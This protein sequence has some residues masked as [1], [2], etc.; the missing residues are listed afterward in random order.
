MLARP[1]PARQ[2][3]S[4]PRISAVRRPQSVA[5][6]PPLYSL[7]SLHA[8]SRRLLTTRVELLPRRKKSS[9]DTHGSIFQRSLATAINDPIRGESPYDH[10]PEKYMYPLSPPPHLYD[11]RPFDPS[12]PLLL[13]PAEDPF[14]RSRISIHGIPGGVDEMMSVFDACLQVGKLDRAALVIT[15]LSESGAIQGASLTELHNQYLRAAID[16][17][18]EQPDSEWAQSLHKW[19]EL[20]IRGKGLP[21]TP[22]TVACM[23]KISLLSTQGPRLE[24]L[25]ARYMDLMPGD[26][27]YQVLSEDD[28]LTQ[29][30]VGIIASIYQPASDLLEDW[31]P[32]LQDEE[33]QLLDTEVSS[34]EPVNISEMKAER[35]DTPE[36][37]AVDQKG[38]GLKT[39]RGVLSFFS[40]VEGRDL[41]KLSYAERREIQA[42][43]E[44]DC[45]DAAISRWREENQALMKMG[46][47]TSLSTSGLNS[48]LYEWQCALESRLEEEFELF[49]VA[50]TREKKNDADQDR[51]ICSP[52]LK[53]STPA[54]LS[55]VT[56]ISV[57]NAMSSVGIDGGI[58]LSTLLSHISKAVE[59][60]I[61]QMIRQKRIEEAKRKAKTRNNMLKLKQKSAT[62][63]STAQPPTETPST[64]HVKTES[65]VAEAESNVVEES[66][67]EVRSWPTLIR[68]KVGVA[69]LSALIDTAKMNV[70]REHPETKALVSQRQPA[71]AH[72]TI[73]RKGKKVGLVM[74]NKFLVELLKR[75]PPADFL[76]RHLPMLVEPE[77]WT[78][79]DKGGFV[80]YPAQLVRIKN[81]EKDQRVYA[82]AAVQRGD[83]EQVSKGLDVLGRTGWRINRPVFDVMLEA[84]NSG[85]PIANI[86]PLDPQIPIPPEPEA[87]D[88]P[89]QRREWLNAVKAAENEKSGLHSER[90][91]M[92]FQFEIARAFKDQ[93]FYFPHNM[94][95]R[96]RAYPI[97]TYLNHMGA[98]HVRGLL[99]FA[100]GKELGE[101]GLRWLKIHLANVFGYDKASL[102][103]RE[104]FVTDHL[105]DIYDSVANPLTGKRWWLKAEDAW[106]CLAT[107]F[108]LKAAL[109]SPDPTKFVSHLPVHQDGTCNGL[110][111]YAALGG[112]IWGAQQVNLLPG[113]RPADVYSA[114][115]DLV[116]EGIAKDLE[117][118]DNVIAKAVEGKI[119]RKVVKQTVMTN[120]YGVTF[121][122]AKA[123]VQKQ[124]DAAYPNIRQETGIPVA[125][126]ASYVAT[127]VFG[128]LSTMFRGAHNIQY[129]L[130]ECAGRVCRALTPEQMDRIAKGEVPPPRT[131]GMRKTTTKSTTDEILG[132]FRST[133]VW[134]T[135]LR[136]PI[137]QPYRKNGTR[138]IS[139]SM[140]DLTLQVPESSDPVNR[141]KQLQAFPPN[142]IHSLDASHMLLS[143]LQC[144][145]RGLSFAAV[146][147][148]F[149]THAADVD[150]MN[151][152][153]RDSF[154]R[155]HS[156][157]VIGRLASEFKARYK[158]SIYLSKV[159]RYSKVGNKIAALRKK[160]KLSLK[161]ELLEERERMRLLASSDPEEVKKG[162]EMQTP[163]SIFEEMS[164]PQ[165][166]NSAEDMEGM[167]LGDIPDV[168]EILASAME[169]VDE[170]GEDDLALASEP[171]KP[172]KAVKAVKA[173]VD[174]ATESDTNPSMKEVM[175]NLLDGVNVSRFEQELS[176]SI[177]K[178]AKAKAK[179]KPTFIN[180][181]LPLDFPEVPEKGDFDVT[182]LRDSQ[183]FFS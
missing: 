104:A 91:F 26:A 30:D 131:T 138:V 152:V 149:W 146:H 163:A 38:L 182:R 52:F 118:S 126:L 92:N 9:Q 89:L 49:E 125:V 113:E 41:S 168:N 83:M 76:A 180:V 112:D 7:Y 133:V 84:W 107:S 56:I 94:D 8:S 79:F 130:G 36:V 175:D 154:I 164:A 129:W 178:T 81:G 62:S 73:N 143:A 123:Q 45:V 155:I 68:T 24:R 88:D 142:F 3:L 2:S 63:S 105:A 181:W 167:T 170:N 18:F 71:M 100:K 87:S 59:E 27:I 19:Y 16:K 97:P 171:V 96:G 106:Q 43:L 80:E 114:V 109:E 66:L 5:R 124:L 57:I 74:P 134:T 148:S 12:S 60:D 120:V 21:Q 32:M 72:T 86:P 135:P 147:D 48:Q 29:Q 37:L 159:E 90:C 42:Q 179:T 98:D 51:C 85:E 140:Q 162:Q 95:F 141:R 44:H 144:D 17:A 136:M 67:F 61:R 13:K 15:R 78:K 31:G 177:Q 14:P 132:Q 35:G 40:K 173:K 11:I 53:Q 70:V 119:T 115:A 102:K 54:R 166:L 93:T 1:L 6:H 34:T 172:V 165:P 122:G 150:V 55:A 69:L 157:D 111:H 158:S 108:E 82:E 117:D 23:L 153:L 50:E 47:N 160:R 58:Q 116:K 110:Q 101:N 176:G 4:L 137:V 65:N 64:T 127:K 151:D 25:V 39:L 77:P 139:T 174:K 33:S 22:E 99:R 156:E 10:L 46:L 128:A 169:T 103:E 161:D 20:N 145:E 183:Y 75:E 121:V 28:I